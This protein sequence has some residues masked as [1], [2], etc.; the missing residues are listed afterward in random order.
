[1]SGLVDRLLGVPAWGVLVVVGLLVF[2]EDALFV[3]FVLPGE[4]AAVLGGVA[5]RLGHV[6]LAG[7]M[8]VVI[9]AAVVGDTVGYEI[10]RHFGPR[11]LALRA[12]EKRRSRLQDA[13]DFLAR[14]GGPAVFLSRWV[15]FLRAVMPALAGT[16]RMRYPV[17]LAFNAAGAIAWGVVVVLAGYLAGESYARVEKFLGRG[18]ALVVAAIVLIA[19]LVWRLR[20]RRAESRSEVEVSQE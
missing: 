6:P 5:A 10:G 19:L 2:S 3:G 8:V 11:I 1:M 20:R 4:T 7:V 12:L 13:Q 15:A 16:A 17:F 14:R 18:A 9:V